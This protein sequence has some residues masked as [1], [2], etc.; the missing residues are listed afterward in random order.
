MAETRARI[1]V[2]TVVRN[3]ERNIR[4]MLDSVKWADEIVAVDQSSQDR[5][6]EI[7][8]GY[9][10]KVFVVEPKGFC[11]P[12]REYA[13]SR[14][15]GEWILYLDADEV[16]GEGLRQEIEG[17]LS[18][19]AKHDCYW[20][21]RRNFF[22]GKWIRGSGWWP[23]PVLRLFRKGRVRFP[24]QIHGQTTA[25]SSNGVLKNALD[26]YTCETIDEYFAKVS[27]Y[28]GILA[29]EQHGRGA[30]ITP[31][32]SLF[33][34]FFLPLG[35]AGQRYFLQA[36]FRD[37]VHGLLIAWFTFLTVSLMQYKTWELQ[38]RTEH[39]DGSA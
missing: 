14:A 22:L 36:G 23:G 29:K 32:N 33:R 27:R 35:R 1:S 37:G 11:E 38:R 5:T 10:D 30:R 28:T 9:T 39:A 18:G 13:A 21:P 6:V 31:A 15:S 25:L 4:R 34:F 20:V 19:N 24:Q 12:D 17:L 2:I 7:C 8:R 3:E 16:V 26:H